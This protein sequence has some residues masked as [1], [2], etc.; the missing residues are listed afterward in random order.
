[1]LA[2]F[3]YVICWH[4]HDVPLPAS[5]LCLWLHLHTHRTLNFFCKTRARRLPPCLHL[6]SCSLTESTEVTESVS[7][8]EFGTFRLKRFAI[9]H[10][11]LCFFSSFFRRPPHLFTTGTSS[12]V[13]C[14][15]QVSKIRRGPPS[16]DYWHCREGQPH[17]QNYRQ[18]TNHWSCTTG[19]HS[20]REPNAGCHLLI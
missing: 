19:G 14:W 5:F 6:E 2:L 16:M 9:R 7:K 12:T 10:L 1:M 20:E 8:Q 11:T 3:S 13:L 17:G 4:Q 15:D 18:T